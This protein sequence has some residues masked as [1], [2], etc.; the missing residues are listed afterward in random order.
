MMPEMNAE[1]VPK[2]TKQLKIDHKYEVLENGDVRVLQTQILEFVWSSREFLS[3]FRGN[4]A[5]LAETRKVLGEEHREKMVLQEQTIL[6]ELGKLKPVVAESEKL[7]AIAYEKMILEGMTKSL[8]LNLEAKEFNEK[9]WVSI[10]LR[11][12][13]ERK[14][15][16]VKSLSSDEQ[17]KYVK[18]LQK[19][20]R[21]GFK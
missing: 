19:L 4:E 7:A 1:P 9:W 16:I 17:K 11:G 15:Q 2:S 13:E 20:K 3:V 6:E 18:V 21:R 8:K 10:W 14:Q 5:A 12:K